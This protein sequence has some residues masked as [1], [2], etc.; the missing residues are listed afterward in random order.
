MFYTNI[1]EHLSPDYIENCQPFLFT[2]DS[3]GTN[4]E[5]PETSPDTTW[6]V[7]SHWRKLSN[8]ES[9]GKDR[10]GERTVTGYTW[11]ETYTKGDDNLPT[12]IKTRRIK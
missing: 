5:I 6:D 1:L 3:S 4:K 11:I 12:I 7:M 2:P 10:Y 9:L 8:P